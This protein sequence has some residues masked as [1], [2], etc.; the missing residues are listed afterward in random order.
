MSRYFHI[1]CLSRMNLVI[2]SFVDI[3][4]S[5][6]FFLLYLCFFNLWI[7]V[8]ILI[9]ILTS[10]IIVLLLLSPSSLLLLF[11]WSWFCDHCCCIP[12]PLSY[13]KDSTLA[14]E[15]LWIDFAVISVLD[16]YIIGLLFFFSFSFFNIFYVKSVATII[17]TNVDTPKQTGYYHSQ[18]EKRCKWSRD[19]QPMRSGLTTAH[20]T[21]LARPIRSGLRT[22]HVR[23]TNR[24]Q[25]KRHVRIQSIWASGM[26]KHVYL[27]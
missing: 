10:T 18:S 5:F 11:C 1:N 7:N 17:R 19:V 14:E 4:D 16:L 20:V 8:I 6:V 12:M 27:R 21:L 22:D 3:G 25:E 24:R 9:I 23:L 2:N 15:E 13:T 26:P